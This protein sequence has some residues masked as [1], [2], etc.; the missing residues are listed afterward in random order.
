MFV[1]LSPGGQATTTGETRKD[2]LLVGTVN[3]IFSFTRQGKDWKQQETMLPDQHISSI[4]FEPSSGTLFAGSYNGKIFASGDQGKNWEQ[5]NQGIV[6]K[7]IY[8]LA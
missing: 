3:G 5:R 7:E 1:C 4:I 6:D 2:R 8:S